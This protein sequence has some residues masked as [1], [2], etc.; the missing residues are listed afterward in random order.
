MAIFQ[1]VGH[2]ILPYLGQKSLKILRIVRPRVVVGKY[3]EIFHLGVGEYTA[4]S[5]AKWE[6]SL[7]TRLK[8]ICGRYPKSSTGREG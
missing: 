3:L 7:P 6:M 4:L 1:R 5:K 2:N 8:M